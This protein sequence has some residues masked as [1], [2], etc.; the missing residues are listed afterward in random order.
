M[1]LR[2]SSQEQ[3]H[4]LLDVLAVHTFWNKSDPTS[5]GPSGDLSQVADDELSVLCA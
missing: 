2:L 1:V 3:E 4:P 5:G